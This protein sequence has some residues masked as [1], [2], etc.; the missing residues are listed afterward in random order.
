MGCKGLHSTNL[1][2]VLLHHLG[3][4]VDSKD[5]ICDTSF[6]E[7]LDLVQDHALVAEFY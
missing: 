7:G 1:C 3:A 6:G 4:V 2:Q 5:D